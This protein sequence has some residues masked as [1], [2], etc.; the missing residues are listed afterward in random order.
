MRPGVQIRP[1]TPTDL[2]QL[3][4]LVLAMTAEVTGPALMPKLAPT[5]RDE[6]AAA[7]RGDPDG[8]MLVAEHDGRVVGCGRVRVLP[9]H[10][11]LRFGADA[12]HAYLEFMYVVPEV[13]GAGVAARILDALE[14][15][16]RSHGVL[17]LTLHRSPKARN[18]YERRGFAEIGEMHKRLL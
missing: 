2:D 5:L 11:M 9:Y 12:G 18:F 7:V 1:A 13:R 15:W 8:A 3:V 17:N 16:A 14:A 6:V 4:E 10:P